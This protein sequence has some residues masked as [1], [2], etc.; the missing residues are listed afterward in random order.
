MN[1]LL[2]ANTFIEA[3]SRYYGMTI[4]PAYWEWLIQA[5]DRNQVFSINPIKQELIN[6]G[7]NLSQ[8]VKT[9]EHIFLT[10]ADDNTQIA[11]AEVAGVAANLPN[12]NE[13]ALQEFLTVADSWLVA[14]ALVTGATIVTHEV[15][16]KDIKKKILIPNVCKLM[17]VSYINTFEML[18][19]LDAEFI[20]PT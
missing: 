13:G 17:D 4:C 3:N 18:H 6:Y 10:E 1:Y 7:D 2:D 11:F 19:N 5:Y 9:N 12:M 8:W 20:L 14:K 15:Y 16:K